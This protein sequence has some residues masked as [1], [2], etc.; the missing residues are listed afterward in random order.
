[1]NSRGAG[2]DAIVV[3]RRES[4]SIGVGWGDNDTAGKD[5]NVARAV[6]I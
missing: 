3:R 1:M 5:I 2:A 4:S 6:A